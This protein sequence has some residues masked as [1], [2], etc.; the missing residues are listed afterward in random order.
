MTQL[1]SW[2]RAGARGEHRVARQAAEV[3]QA[4]AVELGRGLAPLRGG[5][6][7]LRMRPRLPCAE[8]AEEEEEEGGG[9]VARGGEGKKVRTAKGEADQGE[10]KGR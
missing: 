7:R 6:L 3:A 4:L 8:A 1:C 10:V 5:A 2:S 9:E